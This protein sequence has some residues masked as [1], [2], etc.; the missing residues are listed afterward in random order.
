MRNRRF[1]EALL[2]LLGIILTCILKISM[3]TLLIFGPSTFVEELKLLRKNN[4]RKSIE[5]EDADGKS[6]DRA[7][8]ALDREVLAKLRADETPSQTRSSVLSATAAVYFN[9]SNSYCILNY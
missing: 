2:I 8:I 9:N 7:F 3:L 4:K 6:L 1:L 5:G